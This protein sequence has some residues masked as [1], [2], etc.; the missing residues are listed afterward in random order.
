MTTHAIGAPKR[1]P[2]VLI[3]DDDHAS[4]AAARMA[5]AE[6]GYLIQEA[7]TGEQA[8]E[9][10]V[11]NRPDIVLLNA[12]LPVTNGYEACRRLRNAPSGEAVPILM[13]TGAEG[14]EAIE[15]AYR[16]GATDF[17]PKPVS[18]T[19]LRQRVR[20]MLRAQRASERL[21]DSEA[22][23][24]A[25][26]RA[27]PDLIF[28]VD[29]AGRF[30]DFQ[31]G[32]SVRPIVPPEYFLGKSFSDVLPA[33][34]A[35]LCQHFTRRTLSTSQTQVFEYQVEE[36][37]EMRD[38]EARTVENG[39]DRVLGIVRD[40]TDRR[41]AE[42]K[43]QFHT[44]HDTLT[45]LPNRALFRY[46]LEGGVTEAR[47]RNESLAVVVL[48]LDRFKQVNE[49]L[50]HNIGD[51]VLN[52][53]SAQLAKVTEAENQILRSR[54]R[55]GKT[56]VARL[57]ADEF[58]V[59]IPAIPNDLVVDRV[60]DQMLVAIAQ[61]IEVDGREV[62]L[63]ASAGVSMFP[64][65]GNDPDTLLQHAETALR[66]AKLQGR[67]S[68]LAYQPVMNAGTSDTLLLEAELRHA[69]ERGEFQSFYQPKLNTQ[70]GRIQGAEALLRWL[71]PKRGILYPSAFLPLCE[72]MGLTVEIGRQLIQASCQKCRTWS[73]RAGRPV[74]V[75]I[76]MSDLEFRQDDL[77]GH[78]RQATVDH[79]FDPRCLELEITE[80]V[81]IRDA[82]AARRLLNE[83]RALGIRVA[84][85]DFGTGYS[86]LSALKGLP[87]DILKI[88]R[89][90]VNDLRAD[91]EAAKIIHTIVA[92]AHSLGMSVVAEGVE[93]EAQLEILQ[94]LGCDEVQGFLFSEA[95]G[96]DLFEA[97]LV[98]DQGVAPAL[99][100][101]GSITAEQ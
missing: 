51:L 69:V 84:L 58:S 31:P 37:G 60:V 22:K 97:L 14:D 59:V 17:Q 54:N 79:A 6:D 62:F 3:A 30:I 5:L 68:H 29:T 23:H 47:Q 13:I 44:Y 82:Q 41:R 94:S 90:F 101:A 38:F 88:D 76:N 66:S 32:S 65:D 2:R 28:Q 36:N 86:S 11:Q 85:D 53:A 96:A 93:T 15:R 35:S 27:I 45:K 57:G 83:L 73:E 48:G 39:P 77:L 67:N 89:S 7:S 50:G 74:P 70:T 25:L 9:L 20:Y 1:S 19:V 99:V 34:V 71:H 4:R 33:D 95:V 63:T 26:L 72:E 87:I 43:L 61:P 24:Q 12:C 92:M 10:F 91:S 16:A 78:I 52:H 75:A 100:R 42:A 56:R 81:L 64:V 46:Q 18:P 49:T 98:Q 80:R 55:Q 40:I 21:R 8:C